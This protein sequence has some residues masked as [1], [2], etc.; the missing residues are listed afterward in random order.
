MPKT[1]NEI[2]S[3]DVQDILGYIPHWVIR[4]GI[5]VIFISLIVLLLGSWFF[6]YPDIITSKIVL[7]TKNPPAAII[8][9]SSG[10]L[11]NIN[12]FNKEVIEQ[13]TLLATIQNPAKYNHYEILV[14]KLDSIK[15]FVKKF[16]TSSIIYFEQELSLGEMQDAYSEFV[17][18][19]NDYLKFLSL[20]YHSKKINAQ[21]EQIIKYNIYYWRLVKQSKILEK[22][23]DIVKNQLE[24]DRKLFDKQA[25][26]KATFEKSESKYL[27]KKYDYEK[28]KT[29]LADTKM[30]LQKIEENILDLNLG[31]GKDANQM[32]ISLNDAY[33]KLQ[34]AISQWEHNYLLKSPVNGKL[35]FTKFWSQ[36]QNVVEGERVFSV[37]PVDSS[38][39]IGKVMLEIKGSGKVDTGQRVIVK[40][41]NYP[42]MEYGMI[43]GIVKTISL[44]PEDNHLIVDVYFPNGMISNYG[45]E[46]VFSQEMQG[47]AEI[48]T[49]ERR[50]IEKLINPI[51]YIVTKQ[52]EL[53]VKNT[54]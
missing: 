10:K 30:K 32:Q 8:A 26:S 9:R 23:V 21:K 7:T 13:G 52:K 4:W 38:K 45:K 16:D 3:E 34:S 5:T 43:D 17:S 37:I 49:E 42:Y 36:N 54:D 47:T 35:S 25:I 2:R 48:I 46:L 15:N 27:E 18:C 40:F 14:A 44:V 29:D 41:D 28:A 31:F 1:K 33:N 39:I 51:K 24:R 20:D 19:Y 53:S 22:E 6:K 11:N 50:L 12:V